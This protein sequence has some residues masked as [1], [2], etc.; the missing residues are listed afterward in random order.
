MSAP[1]EP[2]VKR[3]SIV[4]TP[5]TGT[6]P[7][8]DGRRRR[9]RRTRADNSLTFKRG[10]P[11]ALHFIVAAGAYSLTPWVIAR[12]QGLSLPHDDLFAAVVY[13]ASGGSA[14]ARHVPPLVAAAIWAN[15]AA[16]A[17]LLASALIPQGRRFERIHAAAGRFYKYAIALPLWTILIAN[18]DRFTA[19]EAHSLRGLASWDLTAFFAR[20][21]APFI[22]WF[23]H[24]VAGPGLTAFASAFDST[25]WLAP[26]AFAGVLLAAGDQR[27]VMNSLIVAYLLTALLAV[28]LFVLLPTFEPWSTNALYGAKDIATKV[29]Y[30][31][32]NASSPMLA[33][34]NTQ[35]RWAA[36]SAFPNL[37]V[38]VP[39]VAAFVLRRH[40]LRAMSLIMI[41]V[42]TTSGLV[43]VYLGRHW[44]IDAVAALPF[45]LSVFAL[46]SRI[47]FDVVLRP[48]IT[49]AAP[50]R[51]GE[52]AVV[53]DPNEDAARWLLSGFYRQR[54]VLLYRTA[55]VRTHIA[56]AKARRSVLRRLSPRRRSSSSRRRSIP[57]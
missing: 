45:A 26:I 19:N 15:V 57:R 3:S 47:P 2:A 23:Q 53:T 40:S 11:T 52:V 50:R 56:L 14:D 27:D 48:R 41:G 54:I 24:A 17:V 8:A 31:H 51:P 34:I 46:E 29:R 16:A 38:A 37:R 35:F 10:A 12:L 22:A 25:I 44:M 55:S 30:L 36:A 18:L 42:A 1:F 39:L 33:R 5:P 28:P 49:A 9:K 43:G 32:S 6:R 7:I 13:L 21:E 4:L 20:A